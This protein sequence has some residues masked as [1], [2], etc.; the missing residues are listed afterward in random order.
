MTVT[1][2]ITLALHEANGV[3]KAG[4]N[5]RRRDYIL[6]YDNSKPEYPKSVLFSVMNENIDRFNLQKGKVYQLEL[7]FSTREANGR[8]FMDANCWRATAIETPAHA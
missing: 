4:K 7:D 2:T 1:G 6:T 8:L 3:S 5:W